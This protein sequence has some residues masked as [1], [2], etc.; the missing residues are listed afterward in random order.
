MPSDGGS[1]SG[2]G[3]IGQTRYERDAGIPQEE[4]F[5]NYEFD[6]RADPS[7]IDGGY[8]KKS[9]VSC[10]Y[11][12]QN[13]PN[14]C[15]HWADGDPGKCNYVGEGVTDIPSG[16]NNGE[17]DYL[18]RRAWCNKYSGKGSD[19]NF[20][21]VAPNPFLSGVIQGEGRNV[22]KS[23]ILGYNDGFCD[24]QGCGR[25]ASGGE[26]IKELLKLPIMCNYYRPWQM[27]V[28]LTVPQS[29]DEAIRSL[30]SNF[31]EQYYR[32][33]K[34]YN[35]SHALGVRL[36]FY[37]QVLNMRATVQKCL[38]WDADRGTT[39]S[40]RSDDTEGYS[41]EI[42]SSI[43]CTCEKEDCAPYKTLDPS[44]GR[45]RWLIRNVWCKAGGPVCN[46]ARTDCPCY[47]GDWLY[48][49]DDSMMNGMRVTANQLME[50][51]FWTHDWDSQGEYDRFFETRPNW[52][53]A[54]TADLYTFEKYTS[55]NDDG[56]DGFGRMMTGKSIHMCMPA[57]LW[58]KYYDPSIY[59]TQEDIIYSSHE[60]KSGTS[61]TE[62]HHFPTLM[63]EIWEYASFYDITVVYPFVA[64]DF[65]DDKMM[66]GCIKTN[67]ADR[68][69][70]HK[71]TNNPEFDF[72]VV[73]G[74]TI[75]NKTVYVANKTITGGFES[76][77][78]YLS[79]YGMSPSDKEDMIKE[80]INEFE[81]ALLLHPD[82]TVRTVSDG[83]SGYFLAGPVR[84]LVNCTNHIVIVAVIGDGVFSFKHRLVESSFCGLL[85][86]QTSFEFKPDKKQ[87]LM[88]H[89]DPPAKA[90][91]VLKLLGAADSA[92]AY[93]AHSR[94]VVNL[95]GEYDEFAYMVEKQDI[96]SD[97]SWGSVGNSPYVVV[98]MKDDKINHIFNWGISKAS[99]SPTSDDTDSPSNSNS[100]GDCFKAGVVVELEQIYPDNHVQ[101]IIVDGNNYSYKGTS[102]SNSQS[103]G[104]LEPGIAVLRPKEQKDMM[105]RYSSR[106]WELSVEA[107]AMVFTP[108]ETDGGK[109]T[110]DPP[111]RDAE[112]AD[113]PRGDQKSP[114][115]RHSG[116]AGKG[117]PGGYPANTQDVVQTPYELSVSSSEFTVT[118]IKIGPIQVMG[119]ARAPNGRYISASAIKVY[120]Y[121][122]TLFCRS[123]EVNH[124]YK[125]TG[126]EE[127]LNPWSGF[128]VAPGGGYTP[129]GVDR[130]AYYHPPC[131]DHL[132]SAG[133][134]QGP[135]WYPYSRCAQAGVYHVWAMCASCVSVI[136]GAPRKDMRFCMNP[137]E[138]VYGTY[139]RS[140]WAGACGIQCYMT[141][142]TFPEDTFAGYAN[143]VNS[144]DAHWYAINKWRLPPFG[145]F[146]RSFVDRNLCKD[147]IAY[148]DRTVT[149]P[150]RGAWAP[151]I[152]DNTLFYTSFNAFDTFSETN[153][154]D[155][156]SFTDTLNYG[157]CT[158]LDEV[159]DADS[160]SRWEEVFSIRRFKGGWYPKPRVLTP[161]GTAS[162]GYVF[163]DPEVAWAW[164][165]FWIPIKRSGLL[166]SVH[167]VRPD[168][169]D[170]IYKAE[171]RYITKEGKTTLK[172]M[173]PERS[174]SEYSGDFPPKFALGAGPPRMFEFLYEN[175]ADYDSKKL[176]WLDNYEGEQTVYA[177]TTGDREFDHDYDVVFD[178]E[179]SEDFGAAEDDNKIRVL[180]TDYITGEEI[181]KAY[182]R[183]I[184]IR[185]RRK[186][187]LALPY[188]TVENSFSV[189]TTSPQAKPFP[190]SYTWYPFA[191]DE[192]ED[193]PGGSVNMVGSF[194]GDSMAIETLTIVGLW[195]STKIGKKEVSFCQP[196]IE[197]AGTVDVGDEG[198]DEDTRITLAGFGGIA[199]KAFN[200][201]GLETYEINIRNAITPYS[202]I[203]RRI[204]EV[205]ITFSFLG[206]EAIAINEV[207]GTFADQ[208]E[209]VEE[210]IEVWE[211]KYLV[212]TFS[213]PGDGPNPDTEEGVLINRNNGPPHFPYEFS[214]FPDGYTAMN[215]MRGCWA[216]EYYE[217][218]GKET[219]PIDTGTIS[220]VEK[221]EQRREWDFT[222]ALDRSESDTLSFQGYLP[223]YHAVLSSR[224]SSASNPVSVAPSPL[225][226]K[227]PIIKWADLYGF[228]D[229]YID[230]SPWKPGG[231]TWAWN[232]KV[233]R[234]NCMV[235]PPVIRDVQ[236]P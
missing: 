79:T 83:V 27:S 139:P 138:V 80:L 168:Y 127:V 195:G 185:M 186:D 183:G 198:D 169:R 59:I 159:G 20:I 64:D 99:L 44:G 136:D 234:L 227:S 180:G 217:M 104:F 78:D 191:I 17:C 181:K 178:A 218:Y 101:A 42:G 33:L 200:I 177:K 12:I 57:S 175:T 149:P 22:L 81:E 155:C 225:I 46:G 232:D 156:F 76:I 143:L 123:V 119:M 162:F 61:T 92:E 167:L 10:Q 62:D 77:N 109:T 235:D 19:P 105:R 15:D 110:P 205:T 184:I 179:Y 53:D 45:S 209:S 204:S 49:T 26:S 55:A 25:G 144:V 48:C 35:T 82:A 196:A 88:G 145:N 75:R 148:V 117:N 84:L 187:I 173:A 135:M 226:F 9:I 71:Y 192:D 73:I 122:S 14:V 165:E 106:L 3:A 54:T 51:R 201:D 23:Q 130:H 96:S 70:Y 124:A 107:W 38:Y 134:G 36:P 112:A 197:V 151:T 39:F 120:V 189:S 202:M 8:R 34:A 31:S 212:S 28:G 115:G 50:L 220:S 47:S 1:D 116:T 86:Q 164:R 13:Q 228:H 89:F 74:Q 65:S 214:F 207:Y 111:T 210:P 142:A 30:S 199:S 222:V 43:N 229:F 95:L 125:A 152:A 153:A 129:L 52:S 40:L 140:N 146:N 24:G 94:H 147:Y 69:T 7:Y 21:C 68:G 11:Y 67:N 213:D 233:E 166:P 215:K 58:N 85:L 114:G 98:Y 230:G 100:A 193:V 216:S 18:G 103:Q 2:L 87:A 188:T 113:N 97:L 5:G 60:D 170:D 172:F 194:S 108:Q 160:R 190:G 66:K 131:G 157:L 41:I 63:Q 219:I 133:T 174:G 224:V 231:H 154:S 150:F 29:Y 182:N 37:F 121:T 208:W 56:V 221:T 32:A 128:S 163:N 141:H 6:I 90:E 72:T 223:P 203:N 132:V 102:Y 118:G 137:S 93:P 206:N 211:R 176:T 161:Y 91:G 126:A 236:W 171:H 158:N 16:Y 4:W